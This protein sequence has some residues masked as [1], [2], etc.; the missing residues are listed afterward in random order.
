MI[1]LFY[2]GLSL[3]VSFVCSS[4]VLY[5]ITCYNVRKPPHITGT[6]IC[7]AL[8]YVEYRAMSG[9]FQNIDPPPPSP[10]SECVL[11]QHQR[12]GGGGT[13][14]RAVRGWWV[15]ISIFWKTPDIGLAS[16]SLIPLRCSVSAVRQNYAQLLYKKVYMY[17]RKIVKNS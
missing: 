2:K 10:P 9:V 5:T 8:T 15:I 11:P 17:K 3:L 1:C 12:R 14:R 4:F 13:P 7:S 6:H 16:Y